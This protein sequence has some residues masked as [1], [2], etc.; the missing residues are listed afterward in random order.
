MINQTILLEEV[1]KLVEESEILSYLSYNIYLPSIAF[2][3]VFQFIL[4]MIVGYVFVKE[5]KGKFFVIFIFTQLIGAIVLF[6]IFIYPIIPQIIN[7][8]F[9]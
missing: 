6:F 8:I 3:W 5:D 1:G 2:Y 9:T 4:T 7:S